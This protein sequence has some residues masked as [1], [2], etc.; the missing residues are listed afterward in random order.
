MRHAGEYGMY[1]ESIVRDFLKFIARRGLD[2]STGFVI[3]AMEDVSMQCDI[4]IFDSKMTPMYEQGDRQ[5]F[6]PIESIFCAG[7][8]KS[9]ISK[10]QFAETLNKLAAVK[11]IGERINSPSVIRR[12]YPG[13]FDPANYPFDLVPSVL[14]RHKLDFDLHNIENEID[15]MYGP[16]IQHRHKHNLILSLS[17]GLFSYFSSDGLSVA[18][19][20]VKG[21][22]LKHR[23]I[24]QGENT[25]AHLQ[26]FGSFMFML[27]THKTLLYPEFSDYLGGIDVGF[28]REQA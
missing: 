6:F 11:A 21:A 27:T 28:K 15:N 1:R 12:M 10:L 16:E 9:K 22:S 4:V 24:W 18:Y 3:S 19:P 7:E 17:D 5:R 26:L 14:I 2:V 8:V 23:L 13:K 25:Y 20:M